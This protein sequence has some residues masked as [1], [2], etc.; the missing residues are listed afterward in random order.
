[1][2]PNQVGN[3]T[4]RHEAGQ[5]LVQGAVLQQQAGQLCGRLAGVLQAQQLL[6]GLRLAAAKGGTGYERLRDCTAVRI[7]TASRR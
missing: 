4:H 7:C 3:T 1:M 6:Q 5:Q 2:N